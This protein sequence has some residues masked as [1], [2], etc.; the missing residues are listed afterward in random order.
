MGSTK[1]IKSPQNEMLAKPASI[2]R[3]ANKPPV[4]SVMLLNCIGPSVPSPKNTPFK[5]T[6]GFTPPSASQSAAKSSFSVPVKVTPTSQTIS[7]PVMMVDDSLKSQLPS[8]S[9]AAPL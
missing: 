3:S 7:A 9:V 5:A 4:W 1:R 6:F 8:S 2:C